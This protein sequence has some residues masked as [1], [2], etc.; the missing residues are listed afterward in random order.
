MKSYLLHR[1]IYTM[2]RLGFY[3]YS[4]KYYVI[5]NY[6]ENNNI[7]LNFFRYV[8]TLFKG[9]FK[10]IK[11]FNYN[12]GYYEYLEIPITTKCSLRCKGCSNLI[13]CYNNPADVDIDILLNSIDVFLKCINNIVYVRVL[14]GE[15][16]VSKNLE[17]IINKL[18]CSDKIQRIEIVTNG[19]IIPK[20]K[21]LLKIMSNK[22]VI[23]CISKYPYV[24]L[25]K[26]IKVLEKNYINYKVD[27]MNFWMDYGNLDER[28]KSIS[29][30]KKQYRKCNHICKSLLNGQLHLCPR[31]SHG[32]DL[33][34]I[35][36]NED[37]YL[38]LLNKNI[39]I[40]EKKKK[41]VE[42]FKK[43]YIIACDYCDFATDKSKKIKVAEQV[44]NVN[45]NISS[46]EK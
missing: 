18:L 45:L 3:Y 24:K 9:I 40:N 16:F 7:I 14:G 38:D 8:I 23:V 44:K 35:K 37:D 27:D 17:Q 21:S 25:E 32:T 19:T 22:R 26:L 15:P 4:V 13:P 41:I 20:N 2:H 6:Y 42:L 10:E 5:D 34:I 29:E 36:G 1:I 11:I 30:L 33:K 46:D 12:F 31:S 39:G 43:K 28:G